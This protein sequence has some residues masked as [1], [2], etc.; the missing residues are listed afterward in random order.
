MG[1][2]RKDRIELMRPSRVTGNATLFQG[3]G[4]TATG[5]Q[6]RYEN[7]PVQAGFPVN[8][9]LISLLLSVACRC[10]RTRNRLR[11]RV[12][13]EITSGQQNAKGSD[14]QESRVDYHKIHMQAWSAVSCHGNITTQLSAKRAPGAK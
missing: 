5:G 14:F 10:T 1:A 3:C 2:G 13:I 6:S 4:S 7:V 11:S 12:R 8:I 9:E